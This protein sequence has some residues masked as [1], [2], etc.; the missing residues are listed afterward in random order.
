MDS[1]RESKALTRIVKAT[2]L[3]VARNPDLREKW[4]SAKAW[5]ELVKACK[6]GSDVIKKLQL[7]KLN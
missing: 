4:V 6:L 2:F 3:Q 7:I 1:R 5:L